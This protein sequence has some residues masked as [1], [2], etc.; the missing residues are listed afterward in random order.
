M[1]G[2]E[3]SKSV[4]DHIISVRLKTREDCQHIWAGMCTAPPPNHGTEIPTHH[5]VFSISGTWSCRR[6]SSRL[7]ALWRSPLWE[8]GWTTARPWVNSLKLCWKLPAERMFIAVKLFVCG[9]SSKTLWENT[10]NLQTPG[11]FLVSRNSLLSSPI[12]GLM[13]EFFYIVS[14]ELVGC[15]GWMTAKFKASQGKE[16]WINKTV[17]WNLKSARFRQNCELQNRK[18]EA[19]RSVLHSAVCSIFFLIRCLEWNTLIKEI[20]GVP[21]CKTGVKP[22]GD[23]YVLLLAVQL[24]ITKGHASYRIFP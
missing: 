12:G 23:I 14:V 18:E 17:S 22:K 16:K 20:D 13:L 5:S 8:V 24:P 1:A 9:S 3:L 2:H 11:R 15:L 19:C 10:H 7:A 4:A 6:P 21:V